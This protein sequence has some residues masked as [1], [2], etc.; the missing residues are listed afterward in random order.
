MT[1]RIANAVPEATE[2]EISLTRFF[3]APPRRVFDMWTQRRYLRQWWGPEGSK[4]VG[5]E[6]DLR[7]GGSF[8]LVVRGADGKESTERGS[9]LELR[10][11]TRLAFMLERD[12]L[13]GEPLFTSVSLEEMGAM[14]RMTVHQSEPHAEPYAHQQLPEWLESLTRLAE[15][16]E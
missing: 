1:E 10:P 15:L 9:Y 12:D 8:R 5:C 6:I 11:P 3:V 14:T 4:V 7:H 2:P 13:P 16:L